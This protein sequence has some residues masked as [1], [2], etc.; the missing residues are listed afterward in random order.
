MTDKVDCK[1][2][3][4][5]LTDLG[6]ARVSALFEKLPVGLLILDVKG[7][8]LYLNAWA[9]KLYN[10]PLATIANKPVVEMLFL[11]N[12]EPVADAVTQSFLLNKVVTLEWEEELYYEGRVFRR[13]GTIFPFS[14]QGG[15]VE[16]VGM[17]INDVTD[18]ARSE[19]RLLK[20]LEQYRLF[21]DH[22]PDAILILKDEEI[23]G[24][25]V[26]SE[27]LLDSPKE[28]LIGSPMWRLSPQQNEFDRSSRE[29][30]EER[31][32]LARRGEEQS[33]SWHFLTKSGTVIDTEVHLAALPTPGQLTPPSLLQAVIRK[34][35]KK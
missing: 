19:K 11:P 1:G 27:E 25:N 16:H 7:R 6:M 14:A 13:Q 22:S 10:R 17:M 9:E 32:R 3:E 23:A 15:T 4:G 26:K 2:K 12:P 21:F 18:R 24:M 8:V 28:T 20:S 33:F 34:N 35:N 31:V 30:L 29:Y 5:I